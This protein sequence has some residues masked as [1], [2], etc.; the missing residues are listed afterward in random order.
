MERNAVKGCFLLDTNII[1]SE[2]LQK[3]DIR[4]NKMKRDADFYNIQSYFSESVKRECKKKIEDTL[5]FFGE[6]VQDIIKRRLEDSKRKMGLPL[7]SPI[8]YDDIIELEKEYS[9]LHGYILKTYQLTQ[10][11]EIIEEWSIN[12]LEDIL[13]KG[14]GI[15]IEQFVLE[16]VMKVLD[17]GSKIQNP[18]D[19]FITFE[20]SFALLKSGLITDQPIID[21]LSSIS[22][23]HPDNEHI[24]SA[25]SNQTT[26]EEKTIFVTNDYSSIIN[27]REEIKQM[28]DITCCDP[29]YAIY[30]LIV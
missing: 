2:I 27:K 26:N 5:K 1:I 29:L 8:T 24:A 14:K 3:D 9:D 20:R 25:F 7:S 6:V 18:Y 23:H 11:I 28:L 19:D 22:T 30:H 4:I 15:S 21:S 17:V 12:Y 16:L 13:K 10:P